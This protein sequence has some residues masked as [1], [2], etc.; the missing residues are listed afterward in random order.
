[1]KNLTKEVICTIYSYKKKM[2]TI[3]NDQC[4]T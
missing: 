2:W 3:N 1:M 4:F